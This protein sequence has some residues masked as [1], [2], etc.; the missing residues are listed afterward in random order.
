MRG[1]HTKIPNYVSS[2]IEF[3]REGIPDWWEKEFSNQIS[4]LKGISVYD[5]RD[6]EAQDPLPEDES[7]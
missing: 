7:E 4:D 2:I 5:G 3:G 6:I 1:F